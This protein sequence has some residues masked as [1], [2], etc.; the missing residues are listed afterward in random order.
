VKKSFRG[1]AAIAVPDLLPIGPLRMSIVN[2]FAVLRAPGV[3]RLWLA[4]V[5]I[6]ISR[7]LELLAFAL[8][9]LELSGSPFLVALTTVLR[10][11]PM[12]LLSM[13]LASFA[14][15]RDHKR[16]LLMGLVAMLGL[17][18]LLFGL[19]QLDAITVWILLVA[20]FANG[21]FWTLEQ[22][23][24]RVMLAEAGGP[25][26]LGSSIGLD[27]A[28]NQL[29]RFLGVA[30]GGAAIQFVGLGGVFACGILLFAVSTLLIA[31][32]PAA[33]AT[34]IR[35][36]GGSLL[37]AITDGLRYARVQR[38]LLPTAAIT[39]IFNLFGFPYVAL[40]PVMG[41]QQLHLDPTAIGLLLGMEA[42]GGLFS[43]VL[44]AAVVPA[45]QF[46]RL[47]VGGTAVFLVGVLAASLAGTATGAFVMLFVAGLGIAGFSSMQVA[48]PIA[49]AA[50]EMR[51]RALG[52]INM[53]IGVSPLGFLH[54]GLLGE[55]LGGALAITVM[56]LEGLIAMAIV[57]A[58][59]PVLLR[60]LE[61]A[62][63]A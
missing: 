58:A 7:W 26:R 33:G 12:F 35:V 38:I 34:R 11:L 14:E 42:L 31:G 63:R 13:P 24:R 16:L 55:L 25:G 1:S 22:T 9:V 39:V 47:Y 44:I 29:T 17:E 56:S 19:V 50:G 15:G 36:G 28:T 4:G 6:G 53:S 40:L 27:I 21:A 5:A 10:M 57:L 3:I 43:A 60:P 41:E 61:L 54:A 52:L 59:W 51:L 45:R 46:T 48:I 8:F 37:R 62:Q 30:G 2:P 32:V 23:L 20:S 49:A 18:C